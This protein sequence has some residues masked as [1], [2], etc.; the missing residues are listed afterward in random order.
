MKFFF[1]IAF[2]FIVNTFACQNFSTFIKGAQVSNILIEILQ[3]R[4]IL[5]NDIS[6]MTPII[7]YDLDE[8]LK[9]VQLSSLSIIDNSKI[10][11]PFVVVNQISLKD[12]K[13]NLEKH[14]IVP[15][16]ANESILMSVLSNDLKQ[17]DNNRS[18]TNKSFDSDIHH[19]K[20]FSPFS[21]K[22]NHNL[23]HSLMLTRD[24]NGFF[25]IGQ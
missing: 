19:I 17:I 13:I 14:N 3:P 2:A 25:K 10:K 9:P 21:S 20:S 15:Y 12:L 16:N 22:L 5:E 6:K 18:A 23:N 4:N 7:N 8:L 1:T 24:E 11:P